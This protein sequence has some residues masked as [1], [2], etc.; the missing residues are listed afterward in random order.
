M[1]KYTRKGRDLY[2]FRY[3]VNEL[4]NIIFTK[5]KSY[6]RKIFKKKS[7][8]FDIILNLVLITIGDIFLAIGLKAVI[9]SHGF[10]T[11][12]L[13]GA[14]L[15]FYYSLKILSPGVWFFI[16][17][18]P[19]FIASWFYV[20][21]KFFF[22][23]L[24][25]MILLSLFMEIVNFTIPVQD[26]FLA[27]LAGGTITGFGMTLILNSRGSSGGVDIIGVILNRKFGIR[28]GSTL[29]VFNAVIFVS[30][31]YILSID[32]MLY[33]IALSFVVSQVFENLSTVFN[34]RKTVIIITCYPYKV[35]EYIHN[36]MR[37]GATFL[38][39]SGSY[40]KEDKKIILTVINNHQIKKLERFIL[41]IDPKSFMI[42]ENT[43]NVVGSGFHSS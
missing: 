12:G 23:S 22:Y 38:H 5:D 13:S 41:S 2:G 19:I 30:S 18:I 40:S 1:S 42:I 6:L 29:F 24:Y 36:N 35:T 37:K 28:I 17:N 14:G 3:D 7:F 25:G 20:G 15:L 16:L 33:S 9:V 43:Y 31:I 32:A 26:K 34:Q 11:G 27:V 4:A 10:M 8:F 39:G 21:R